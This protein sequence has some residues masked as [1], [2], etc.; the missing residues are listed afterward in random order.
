M[1]CSK[2]EVAEYSPPDATS[3]RG[4][5][6]FRDAG[7]AGEVMDF[8]DGRGGNAGG[9]SVSSSR[10][11][12]LV[13]GPVCGGLAAGAAGSGVRIALS[14]RCRFG[15]VNAD[16]GCLADASETLLSTF[17][18]LADAGSGFLGMTLLALSTLDR[19]DATFSGRRGAARASS[20]GRSRWT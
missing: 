9:C 11:P 19:G 13:V 14:D 16:G 6:G 5:R 7:S 4:P 1:V 8:A 2:F 18:T 10:P 12:V 3:G 15:L 17:G 20:P